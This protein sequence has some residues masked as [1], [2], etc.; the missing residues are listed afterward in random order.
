M[1][2]PPFEAYVASVKA[3]YDSGEQNEDA[4]GQ[5]RRSVRR[6]CELEGVAPPEWAKARPL[7]RPWP[8]AL[9][10]PSLDPGPPVS[11]DPRLSAWRAAGVGRVV[12]VAR[13]GVTLF[14]YGAP[15]RRFPSIEAA[16]AY[17]RT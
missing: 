3:R 2:R 10:T 8:K 11:F 9:T 12:Q 6:R 16:V 13:H 15:P 5:M 14:E 7:G 4:R 17:A 1:A